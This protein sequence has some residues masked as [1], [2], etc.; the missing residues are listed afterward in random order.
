MCIRDSFLAV[1]ADELV[2]D[3]LKDANE[4][5]VPATQIGRTGGTSLNFGSEVVIPISELESAYRNELPKALGLGTV[6]A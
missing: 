6:S 2:D 3:F 4:R 5:D 1:V